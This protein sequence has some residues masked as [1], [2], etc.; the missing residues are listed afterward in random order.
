[1][2]Q[3]RIDCRIFGPFTTAPRRN[4]RRSQPEE[5]VRLDTGGLGRGQ[6]RLRLVEQPGALDVVDGLHVALA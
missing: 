6:H 1:M 3:T 4:V 2:H 5:V